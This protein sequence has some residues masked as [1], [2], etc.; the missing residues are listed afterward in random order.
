MSLSNYSYS[1]QHLAAIMK[2]MDDVAFLGVTGPVSFDKSHNRI[3]ITT[4]IKQHFD[5]KGIRIV[6]EVGLPICL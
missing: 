6:L 2:G 3:G 4:Y 5:K 1:E